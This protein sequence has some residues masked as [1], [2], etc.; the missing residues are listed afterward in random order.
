MVFVVL[1]VILIGGAIFSSTPSLPQLDPKAYWGPGDYKEDDPTIK[2]FQIGISKDDVDD[3]EMRLNFPLRIQSSLEGSNFNYGFNGETL[4][5]IIEYWRNEYDW[6]KRENHLNTYQHFKTEIEGLSIHFM[7][8]SPSVES[9]KEVKVVPLLLIH[10]WPGSFVEFYDILPKLIQPQEGSNVIFDVICPS[11]PGFG[12]SDA[13]AKI[14]V[15]TTETG[16]IFLKLMKRLGFEQFYLQGGDWG[17]FV[18]TDMATMY[19]ENILGVHL[20]MFQA[21]TPGVYAKWFLGSFL[22]SGL[23]MDPKDEHKI[24][25]FGEK[26]SFIALESGYFHIQATKPDTIGHAL[27]QSPVSLAAYILEKFSTATDKENTQ[28][29]DGGLTEKDFPIP[30]DAMLDNICIYWFTGSITSSVRFYAENVGGFI[31]GRDLD[32]IPCDVPSSFAAFPHELMTIPKNFLAHKFYDIFS[33]NDMDAGG[34][35]AAME[36]PQLLAKDLH[37]FVTLVENRKMEEHS[38]DKL[39]EL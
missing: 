28:K 37:K 16:Q 4:E 9:A 5:K 34:H 11:I 2:S 17:S 33:Y 1:I 8:A 25:P 29:H 3:F 6:K 14:G 18:A 20:N 30:L 10:G 15:R 13:P 22:P 12:F 27:A 36:R 7:R 26:M 24:Y 19:N 23:F 38:K 31:N 35:F 39:N 21:E 32:M